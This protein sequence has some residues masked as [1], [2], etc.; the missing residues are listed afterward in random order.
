VLQHDKTDGR[1]DGRTHAP[2]NT[3]VPPIPIEGGDI[4]K[5]LRTRPH[6]RR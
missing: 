1:T 3:M 5:S 6:K 4:K 2:E